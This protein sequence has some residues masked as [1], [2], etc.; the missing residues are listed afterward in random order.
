MLINQLFHEWTFQLI[1]PHMFYLKDYMDFERKQ[2]EVIP[3]HQI[4]A[5]ILISHMPFHWIVP[6]N[7]FFLVQ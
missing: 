6:D 5:S 7:E 2:L 1:P 3:L 4:I